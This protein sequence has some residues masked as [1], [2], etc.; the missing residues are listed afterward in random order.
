MAVNQNLAIP[1]LI[2]I[3]PGAQEFRIRPRNEPALQVEDAH[4]VFIFEINTHAR[5]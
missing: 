3:F 1:C 2:Q 5:R 4:I